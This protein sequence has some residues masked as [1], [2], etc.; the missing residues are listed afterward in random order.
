LGRLQQYLGA[1]FPPE[2]VA[3]GE[4][5]NITHHFLRLALGASAFY[6]LLSM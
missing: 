5:K 1:V 3:A 6:A 2:A 4:I